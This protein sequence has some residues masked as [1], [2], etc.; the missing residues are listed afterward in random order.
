MKSVGDL[1]L[2][3]GSWV[4]VDAS[5]PLSLLSSF[6]LPCCGYKATNVVAAFV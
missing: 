6:F 1:R 2:H 5:T 3:S 4:T